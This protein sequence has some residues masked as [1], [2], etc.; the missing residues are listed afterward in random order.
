[1]LLQNFNKFN[2]ALFW[3]LWGPHGE[4][5][6]AFQLSRGCTLPQWWLLTPY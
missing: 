4:I 5:Y 1:M 6:V 2:H 3:G